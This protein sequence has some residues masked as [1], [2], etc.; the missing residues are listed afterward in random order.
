MGELEG[1]G[2][3][4]KY[5]IVTIITIDFSDDPTRGMMRAMDI[6]PYA[7]ETMARDP[8]A[9]ARADAARHRLLRSWLRCSGCV[10]GRLGPR[11]A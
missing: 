1:H 4:K 5:L 3:A 9:Q 7:L 2:D 6:N 11:V 10:A 8:I